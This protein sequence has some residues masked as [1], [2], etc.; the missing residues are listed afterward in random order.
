MESKRKASLVGMD[1]SDRTSKRLKSVSKFQ[2]CNEV[3]RIVASSE[4]ERIRCD[5]ECEEA[6][7]KLP[8]DNNRVVNLE[9]PR[10]NI[11]LLSDCNPACDAGVFADA[12]ILQ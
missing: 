12:P 6:A 8:P 5:A 4:K 2:C 3:R 11:E 1:A 9:S 10:E 7:L